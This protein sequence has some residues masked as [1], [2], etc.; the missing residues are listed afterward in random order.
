M[1][2][3][4]K[5]LTSFSELNPA[6]ARKFMRDNP[7]LWR[8]SLNIDEIEGNLKFLVKKFPIADIREKH[9]CIL[10]N[11]VTIQNREKVLEECLFMKREL[12]Q[13]SRYVAVMN[14][15]VSVLKAYDYIHSF[16]DVPT[17]LIKQLNIEVVVPDLNED[18]P[19]NEI[20]KRIINEYCKEKLLMSND[21]IMRS[22]KTYVNI[23]HRSISSIVKV[24]D[25]IKNDLNFSN[26]RIIKHTYLLCACGDNIRKILQE[27]P[28]IDNTDIREILYN[29]PKI[30]MQP[31]ETLQE[32]IKNIKTFNIPEDSIV[33]C[34]E[35][36]TLSSD[37][38]YNR[39]FELS[40]EKDF[41]AHFTNPRFLRLIHY[42][43]KVK[44]RMEYLKSLKVRCF[45]I[46]LLSSTS[47]QFERFAYEGMDRT[48]GLDVLEFLAHIFKRSVLEMREKIRLHPHWL[49]APLIE[50]KNTYDYLRYNGFTNDEI[51]ES[52]IILLYPVSRLQ[53]KLAE[54]IEWKRENDENKKISDVEVGKISNSKVLNLCVYFLESEYHFMGDGIFDDQKYDKH[55]DPLLNVPELPK[56]NTNYRYGMNNVKK[57]VVAIAE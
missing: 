7:K 12:E 5:Y 34:A 8:Y 3:F 23:K 42:N 52:L 33:K 39:L 26:E 44:A 47:E 17:N 18:M 36:L 11:P 15:S 16:S 32:I 54:M 20:R 56:I 38:V 27:I 51:F 53:P 9:S 46:H 31:V 50:I 35:V 28:K 25:V 19:L 2:F 10:V 13:L 57:N 48:K 29:R 41:Q 55:N 43:T 30:M 24:I 22:R 40:K 45:S 1:R 49:Q 6:N 4:L 21:E 14:K 37:T